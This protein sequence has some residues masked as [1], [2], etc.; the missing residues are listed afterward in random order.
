[1]IRGLIKRIKE[2]MKYKL[3][4]FDLDGTII[5]SKIDIA[6]SVNLTFEEIGQPKQDIEL[7]S[8]HVGLGI[9]HLLRK[10]LPEGINLED[11][12]NAKKIFLTHYENNVCEKTKLYPGVFEGLGELTGYK[13]AILS[14]KPEKLS[15]MC[16]KQLGI[17]AHFPQ[18][19]GG[20]TFEE[21]KPD[22]MGINVLKDYYQITPNEILMIGDSEVDIQTGINARVDTALVTYGF[23]SE[24]EL[25]H[26]DA[27]IQFNCFNDLLKWIKKSE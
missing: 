5:D 6:H 1:M 17:L 16:L 13:K 23:R 3:L 8:K 12:P 25:N 26:V 11:I 14:N 19:I 7:I 9:G 15:L 20:D 2:A 18:I 21:K 22:P 27:T 24:D 10:C 4:I